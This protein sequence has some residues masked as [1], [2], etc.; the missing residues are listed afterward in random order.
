MTT[1]WRRTSADGVVTRRENPEVV[2]ASLRGSY[3]PTVIDLRDWPCDVVLRV[4]LADSI[5][6]LAG[7]NG[8]WQS[9]YTARGNYG[10]IKHFAKWCGDHDVHELIEL[11]ANRWN[12]Y[13]LHLAGG[14]TKSNSR[15]R[16]VG[17]VRQVLLRYPQRLHPGLAKSLNRRLPQKDGNAS[18]PFERD[19][20]DAILK[21][22]A[23][24]PQSATAATMR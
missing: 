7:V 12:S 24:S 13:L 5:E 14:E 1:G 6:A 20:Y 21:A 2:V 22:A 15:R 9:A 3:T 4:Q 8:T 10:H 19:I 11:N 16:H 18:Q 17:A 23:A